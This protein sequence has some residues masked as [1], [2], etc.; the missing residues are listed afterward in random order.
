MTPWFGGALLVLLMP[1]F[2]VQTMGTNVPALLQIAAPYIPSVLLADLLRF[3]FTYAVPW[4]QVLLNLGIVLA[5]TALLLG[6]VVWRVRWL[7]R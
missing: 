6:L 1:L 4:G 3:S 2:L 7:D 5:S